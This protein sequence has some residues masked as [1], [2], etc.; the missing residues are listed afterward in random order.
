[1]QSKHQF[2][3]I[4]MAVKDPRTKAALVA[5]LKGLKLGKTLSISISI[6]SSGP[7]PFAVDIAPAEV[8]GGM[9]GGGF[10][11]ILRKHVAPDADDRRAER[12][13]CRPSSSTRAPPKGLISLDLD[14]G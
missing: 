5:R 1:M 4:E 3:A 7:K 9:G 6:S 14:V 2:D 11:G 8:G 13:R 10:G 12:R